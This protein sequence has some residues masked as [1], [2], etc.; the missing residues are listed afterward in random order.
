MEKRRLILCR[1]IQGSGKTVWAKQWAQEDP[2][3][4][5][6]FNNDDVRNMFGQY[7]V[8]SREKM[9]TSF[10][11]EFSKNAMANGYNIVVDNMNLNPKEIAWWSKEIEK[12][13]GNYKYKL[14]FKDFFIPVEE[15]ILRDA[16]RSNPV[17][18]KVIKETWKRYRETIT[19]IEATKL[20]A[21]KIPYDKN[22]RDAIIVDLDGT[23]CYRVDG[24]PWFGEG[25][26]S[27]M[28]NDQVDRG[29]KEI[30][31]SIFDNV[32]VIIMTGREASEEVMSATTQW[33]ADNNISY[34]YIWFRPLK[35]Y[36]P[37]HECKK[38]I[39]EENIKGKFNILFTLEDN[40]KNVQMWREKGLTC[41]QPNDGKF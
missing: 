32:T 23:L 37:A 19:D 11:S 26:A 25:A 38:R 9:V 22:L 39:Y 28:L 5:I 12:N 20:L 6:R 10:K 30:V 16:M 3:N 31:S 13:Q 4:R 33:L 8:P 34:D 29:V 14:E 15:C 21:S 36:S 35:D 18:E 2:E 27:G 7:W 40:Y 41:L 24:R 17:G 1:G